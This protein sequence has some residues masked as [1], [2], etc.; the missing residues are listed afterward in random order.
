MP[1]VP[2]SP[3]LVAG[4][5]LNHPE[6]APSDHSDY[7]MSFLNEFT[8]VS[9]LNPIP[10]SDHVSSLQPTRL[11]FDLTLQVTNYQPLSSPGSWLHIQCI[12]IY[13]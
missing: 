9:L 7:P 6:A 5:R 11:S 12:Y 10:L 2:Q 1:L 3:N 13:I 8:S 4:L